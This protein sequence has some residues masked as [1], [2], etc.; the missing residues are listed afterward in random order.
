M[1][2]KHFVSSAKRYKVEEKTE[3]GR[4]FTNTRNKIGPRILPCGTPE[5]MGRV[6]EV[7]PLRDTH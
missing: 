2:F 4:S 5:I 7:Q 6:F 1:H 3:D